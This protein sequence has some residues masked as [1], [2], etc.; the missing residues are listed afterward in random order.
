MPAL[1]DESTA[2]W[3]NCA[4]AWSGAVSLSGISR[5]SRSVCRR[6]RI[7][8]ESADRRAERCPQFR[9]DAKST[10]AMILK[11]VQNRGDLTP[12][13]AG[14]EAESRRAAASGRPAAPA[15]ARPRFGWSVHLGRTRPG[16]SP[17]AYQPLVQA[18]P[19]GR[20]VP[21]LEC[22]P[23]SR[24]RRSWPRIRW[25]QR[26]RAVFSSVSGTCSAS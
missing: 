25:I 13:S 8:L 23:G 9:Q 11:L 12:P 1:L 15:S 4:I 7:W 20:R 21:P 10:P 17:I 22:R 24:K 26:G 5:R 14:G 19:G 3:P 16:R 18:V 2:W 6:D